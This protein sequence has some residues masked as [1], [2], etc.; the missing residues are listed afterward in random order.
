MR[1]PRTT[2]AP[3]AMRSFIAAAASVKELPPATP[4]GFFAVSSP[5]ISTKAST[6]FTEA[7]S[8]TLL[9]P[10]HVS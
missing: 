9:T 7:S 5:S 4:H 6:I 2:P 8:C 10:I 1:K 3:L